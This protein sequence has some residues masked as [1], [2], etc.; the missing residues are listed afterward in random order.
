VIDEE[1]GNR[2]TSTQEDAWLV[3]AAQ[4][5]D[6]NAGNVVLTVDGAEHRGAFYRT[7]KDA[8]LDGASIS[9][10]N[11]GRTPVQAVVTVS[12]NPIE[13]EPAL[14]HGYTVER[15]YYR[16]DGSEVQLSSVPQND[17]LVVVLKVTEAEAKEA[18][19]LL[20]DRLPAGFE[21]DNPKLVDSDTVASLSWLKRDVEPAHT[22][23][24]DD[25]FVVAFDRKPDQPAYFTVAYM[26]RAVSPGTYVHPSAQVEDMYRPERYG[27]TGF[28]SVEIVKAR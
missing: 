7:Y 13:P 9:L 16:L 4:A 22:E 11:A 14:S 23:Y 2:R 12:G 10:A 27:R 1:R 18:R 5:M 24:R 17:R 3:M 26:V 21:I 28:G 20:V 6:R 8:V 19:L 15:S 25:R